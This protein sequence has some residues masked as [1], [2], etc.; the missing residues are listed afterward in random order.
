LKIPLESIKY[1]ITDEDTRQFLLNFDESPRLKVLEVGAHD[2]PVANILSE[3]DYSV[4]GV[5]LR[6]YNP[7]Q[8]IES[9]RNSSVKPVCNY[10]YLRHDFCDLPASFIKE[11]VGTFDVAISLSAVEHFGFGTYSECGPPQYHYDTIACRQVWQL[12]KEGGT[13]YLTIPFC[14][15]HQDN[16]PHWRI[17]D[18]AT[19]LHRLVQDFLVL[20][21]SFFVAGPLYLGNKLVNIGYPITQQEVLS[22]TGTE[23]H[24]SALLK[25]QKF[26][27]NR[28]APDGR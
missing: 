22:Y 11:H 15:K 8:D 9:S 16:P 27:Y 2:E 13:F 14:G 12:L 25:M 17:Y 23:P 3:C 4:F 21:C 1:E 10:S 20:R 24:I 26:S 19:L 28:L 7:N 5:D 18:N 6:E